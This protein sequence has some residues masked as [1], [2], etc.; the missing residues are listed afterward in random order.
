MSCTS[1]TQLTSSHGHQSDETSLL[2]ELNQINSPFYFPTFPDYL[3]KRRFLV[4]EFSLLCVI[5]KK[6]FKRRNDKLNEIK[7]SNKK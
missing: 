3:G 2:Y 1:E 5:I 4:T 7:T 6:T